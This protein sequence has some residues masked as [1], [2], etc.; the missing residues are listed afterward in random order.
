M[1]RVSQRAGDSV[2]GRWKPLRFSAVTSKAAA[3]TM[4]QLVAFNQHVDSH[5]RRQRRQSRRLQLLVR[6]DR[7]LARLR[8]G[9]GNRFVGCGL[10][11]LSRRAPAAANNGQEAQDYI[12]GFAA[13]RL[14]QG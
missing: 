5:P 7:E 12:D 2:P 4:E 1:P 9:L 13:A 11:P 10:S 6:V 14:S 3:A 8:V